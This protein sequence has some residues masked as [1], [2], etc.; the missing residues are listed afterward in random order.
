MQLLGKRMRC[1]DCL[2]SFRTKN[3]W[4]SNQIS[5]KVFGPAA[6]ISVQCGSGSAKRRRL[7]D[8]TQAAI[9]PD[10]NQLVVAHDRWL[11][12]ALST[13]LSGRDEIDEVMQETYAAAAEG[14]KSLRKVDAAGPWLYQIAIRQALMFRRRM[15]RNRKMIESAKQ[16]YV[17][18]TSGDS[19]PLQWLLAEE[20]NQLVRR[21]MQHLPRRDAE[22]LLLKYTENW[23]YQQIG[24]HLGISES[25]V[26]ARLHRARQRLRKQLAAAERN[27]LEVETVK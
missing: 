9:Q 21:S 13:R 8:N 10:L 18:Q 24:T 3:F 1:V 2:T 20:R 12:T 17:D 14:L 6:T 5:C 4:K 15:G 7:I 11:R 26:E 19:N 27:P 16:E 23:S 22:I 25:A